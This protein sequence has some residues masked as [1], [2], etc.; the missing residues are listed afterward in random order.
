MRHHRLT[1]CAA[2]GLT[3][4]ALAASTAIAQDQDLRSPDARAAGRSV[5]TAVASP[6]PTEGQA[7]PGVVYQLRDAV[8][9]VRS[10]DLRSPD[11]RD[12]AAGRG[13]FDA[14]EVIVV[15]LPQSSPAADGGI[16]W[17][18]AGIG[19]GAMLGLVVLALG[20]SVALVRRRHG[21]TARRQP[22]TTA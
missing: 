9:P 20:G 1:H 22:A 5:S 11:T 19:A 6:R 18:V 10:Q 3:V 12:A 21:A 15:K 13:T 4:A 16:E 7:L 14:P 8:A 17:G 2:L